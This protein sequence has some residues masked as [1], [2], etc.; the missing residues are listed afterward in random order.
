MRR[1]PALTC[2]IVIGL[3]AVWGG[4]RAQTRHR[5][6]SLN[7]CTDQMLL[8]LVPRQDIVGVTSLAADCS[9]AVMC[10]AARGLPVIR[11]TA[12][13]VIAVRPDLVL[14]GVYTAATAILAARETGLPV[15]QVPPAE[16]L[17]DIPRQIREVARAVGVPER[18]EALAGAF[19][20][21]LDALRRVPSV[22]DPVAA[23]YGANGFVTDKGSL[24]DDVLTHAGLRNFTTVAGMGRAHFL[25][26]EMLIA[27]PPDLLV[28]DRSGVGTS[29]AQSM[30]DHPA[31]RDAFPGPHRVTIPARL[32]LCG[33]PQ[34]L[35]ALDRLARARDALER[36]NR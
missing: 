9:N 20:R 4:A 22:T 12:E 24:S 7:L 26:I 30:L 6:V 13:A 21:R 33:L 8:L 15:M 18:G 32:W 14:G 35:D 17:D 25:P 1:R 34:T 31:L 10:D 2:L 29:L 28:V 36:G 19:A 5:I 11:Q 3:V 23:I 16:R 27:R